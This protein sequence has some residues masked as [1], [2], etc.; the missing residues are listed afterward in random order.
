MPSIAIVGGGFSGAMTAL[1]ILRFEHRLRPTVTLFEPSAAGVGP[2]LAYGTRS[3]QHFLNV[4]AGNMSAWD[5]DPQHFLS[6]LQLR[7]PATTGGSFVP[8]A[9]Y[10]DYLREQVEHARA[11]AG[12]QF[13]IRRA[14]VKSIRRRG[15]RGPFIIESDSGEPV[16]ADH[17][18]LALGNFPP[19][20]VPGVAADS[21]VLTHPA[22]LAHPWASGGTALAAIKPDEPVLL[23]GSG[24]TM[25]DIVMTLHARGHAGRMVALS[26]H[27]LLSRP[28]RSPARP[29]SH[30]PPPAAL[31]TWDGTTRSLVRIL[32]EAVREHAARGG[33][34]GGAGGAGSGA[35]GA[36]SDWRDVVASLRPITGELWKRLDQRERARFLARLRSYWEIVRHRAAPETAATVADLIAARQLAVRAGSVQSIRVATD[37]PRLLEVTFRPRRSDNPQTLR[38]A[39]LINCLG[40][41]TDITRVESPLVRQLLADGLITPDSLGQGIETD[42]DGTPLGA[43]GAAT[44]GLS[45]IGPLRKGQSW[46][47]TAVPELRRQATDVARRVLLN[48]GAEV[49]VAWPA[50]TADERV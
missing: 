3:S 29:P 30:R 7:F 46:E 18:V 31:A 21:P 15:D 20:R 22:Y 32:R 40:P 1:N 41:D 25:M 36:S 19:P 24:L 9:W 34:G 28:H 11:R 27:G 17:V 33:S 43:A 8:R 6:W 47:N 44:H 49:T 14:E 10:G 45:V 48:L 38:V 37:T 42:A 4:P 13:D 26:R 2:G 39:R 12:Q 23:L 16:A 35:A 50:L 5:Q